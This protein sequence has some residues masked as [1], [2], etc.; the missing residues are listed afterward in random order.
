RRR[1]GRRL[2]EAMNGEGVRNGPGEPAEPGDN[3]QTSRRRVS[4][5]ASSA[6]HG[7]G[8][9]GPVYSARGRIS[10]LF[11]YCSRTCAVQPEVRLTAK[12]GVNSSIAT[13]SAWY[14]VAE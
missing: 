2:L 13:P 8:T 5:R 6:T 1:P 12:I 4:Q 11:A 7:C 14:V 9:G 10:R 3:G